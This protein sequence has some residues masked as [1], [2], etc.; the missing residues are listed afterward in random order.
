MIAEKVDAFIEAAN[1]EYGS[2]LAT[3]N[4]KP[5]PEDW[6]GSLNDSGLPSRS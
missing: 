6:T 1:K 5:K 2:E 4:V 3:D